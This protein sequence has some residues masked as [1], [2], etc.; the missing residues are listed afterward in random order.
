MEQI[1][2]SRH[3]W[4]GLEKF[5]AKPLRPVPDAQHI[6]AA[7]HRPRC[8]PGQ[9]SDVDDQEGQHRQRLIDLHRMAG[10]AIAQIDAPRQGGR[11]AESPVRQPLEHAAQPP[12]GD[13]YGERPCEQSPGRSA[14]PARQLVDLHPHH[15]SGQGAD[16]AVRQRRVGRHQGVQRS[17]QPGAERRAERQAGRVAG[18]DRPRR[19]VG[20]TTQPPAIERK[21]KSCA[22]RPTDEVKQQMDAGQCRKGHATNRPCLPPRRN[23]ERLCQRA[24]RRASENP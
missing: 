11:R 1:E 4:I 5:P 13:P 24:S 7:P 22:R 20:Q 18:S 6:E 16:H 17:G 10:D 15:R 21:T 12:H 2:R 23:R 8:P 14:H 19:P 3:G 9:P